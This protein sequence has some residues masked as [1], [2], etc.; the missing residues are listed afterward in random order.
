AAII[1]GPWHGRRRPRCASTR[2]AVEWAPPETARINRPK[3]GND[4]NSPAIS[5][6]EIAAVA[7]A[8]D[9]LLFPLDRLSD[10]QRGAG[11][12]AADLCEGAAGGVLL[13][14]VPE[15]LAK[16]QQRVGSLGS[17]CVVAR[18]Q[19]EQLGGVAIFLALEQ[20]L[21]QPIICIRGA[22]VARVFLQEIAKALFGETVIFAQHVAIGEVELVT[23][24]CG[25]WE[26][27]QAAA[28]GVWIAGWRRRK[29]SGRRWG[30]GR[31]W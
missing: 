16:P 4:A 27:R 7:S 15:R 30:A 29:C 14:H 9:T 6:S 2:G 20:S 1:S 22:R 25:R 26:R 24:R 23:R 18:N 17:G 19:Q 8:M 5:R 31:R 21:A 12:F 28:S 3:R 11:I 13:A 10:A